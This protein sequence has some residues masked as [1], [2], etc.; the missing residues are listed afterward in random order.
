M[1]SENSGRAGR[2]DG[3]YFAI[4]SKTQ[5][6]YTYSDRVAF[7]WSAFTAYSRWSNVTV[8]QDA[9]AGEGV[10]VSEIDGLKF[11]GLSG[12]VLLRLLARSPGQP[13]ALTVS[14][15]PRWSRVDGLT[16]WHAE[17]YGTELKLFVDVALSER[18]FAAMNI[19]YAF[20][21]QRYHIVNAQWE[22]SSSTLISAALTAQLHAAEKQF[23]EGI[24]L[25]IEGTFK[26]ACTGLGLDHNVG[27]AFFLGP[28]FAIAFQGGSMLNLVW[29]PQ[30][31]P[32]CRARPGRSI[33]TTTSVTNFA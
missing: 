29:T 23:V 21:T 12:E 18:L 14:A 27:N 6:N 1:A 3:S 8:A 17:G 5:L 32:A 25:G 4:S 7:A 30:V 19:N 33:S 13:F 9:L 31:A 26:S 28:T 15:E 22:A 10:N 2:R 24:F 11:D 20:G 16:G